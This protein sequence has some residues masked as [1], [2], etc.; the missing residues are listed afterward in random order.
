MAV[1]WSMKCIF[2]PTP[3]GQQYVFQSVMMF[4]LLKLKL[5]T[6]LHLIRC[7][8]SYYMGKSRFEL[9]GRDVSPSFFNLSEKISLLFWRYFFGSSSYYHFSES[10]RILQKCCNCT[11]TNFLNTCDLSNSFSVIFVGYG[12]IFLEFCLRNSSRHGNQLQI[13][14]KVKF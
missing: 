10:T 3:V 8:L 11:F 13:T 2:Y 1:K 9:C 14:I 4:L 5:L 7:C 6:S 12:L